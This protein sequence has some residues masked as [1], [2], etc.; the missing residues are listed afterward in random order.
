MAACHPVASH[1]VSA[2][3]LTIAGV[4][5]VTPAGDAPA[6]MY[7][8]IENTGP[9]TDTL[10]GVHVAGVTAA[11]LHTEVMS[12]MP[13]S[14]RQPMSPAMPAMNMATMVATPAVPVPAHSTLRLA[15][16]GRHV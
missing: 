2:G 6:A 16:G 7:F 13:H 11:E 4:Y 12:P 8:T 3:A 1:G 14:P 15:P 5:L 10:T 9:T